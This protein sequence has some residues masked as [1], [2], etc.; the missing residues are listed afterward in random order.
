MTA[1]GVRNW[2]GMYVLCLL[3]FLGGY[4]FIAPDYLL[5][6]ETGDRV[7]SFEIILPLLIAQVS[8][9]YRF[10]TDEQAHR[11]LAIGNLPD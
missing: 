9:V 1:S 5:P 3:G 4:S 10:Y 6:L 7:A 11:R 8:A 2:L